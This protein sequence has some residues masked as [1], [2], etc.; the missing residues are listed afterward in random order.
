MPLWPRKEK[1]YKRITENFKPI[2]ASLYEDQSMSI[3]SFL[4]SFPQCKGYV[5]PTG[6]HVLS[7]V[8]LGT[9]CC[10]KSLLLLST[11]KAACSKSAC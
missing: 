10:V 6:R 4:S 11:W 8:A 5:Q 7:H 2:A 1:D 3:A 9:S